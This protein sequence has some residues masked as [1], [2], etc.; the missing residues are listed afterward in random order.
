MLSFNPCKKRIEGKVYGNCTN[1]LA[2]NHQFVGGNKVDDET[3]IT[4]YIY[5]KLTLRQPSDK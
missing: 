5:N 2:Y 1:C 4:D 3:I